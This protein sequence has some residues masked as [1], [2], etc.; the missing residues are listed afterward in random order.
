MLDAN[1]FTVVVPSNLESNGYLSINQSEVKRSPLVGYKFALGSRE[2]NEVWV[3]TCTVGTSRR[4]SVVHCELPH[5]G[6]L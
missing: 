6:R 4:N 3:Q 5:L 1:A 2:L